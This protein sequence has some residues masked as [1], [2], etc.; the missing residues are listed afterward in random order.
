MDM[1]L[2]KPSD[3]PALWGFSVGRWADSEAVFEL[4]VS[5]ENN[6]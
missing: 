3:R 4:K 2:L 5:L 6:K 1:I